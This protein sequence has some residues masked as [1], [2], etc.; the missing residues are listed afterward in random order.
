MTGPPLQIFSRVRA[1][2]FAQARWLN[3]WGW[4]LQSALATA[5]MAR[6][7]GGCSDRLMVRNSPDEF[8]TVV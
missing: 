7:V 1:V 8:S 5:S 4:R 2:T 6:L 3:K